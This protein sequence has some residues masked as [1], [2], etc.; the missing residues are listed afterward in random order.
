MSQEIIEMEI[1]EAG[2]PT[3]LVQGVKGKSC[4]DLTKSLEAALGT[5]VESR[6]TREMSEAPRETKQIKQR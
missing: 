4:K 3:I 2:T 5:T 6:P 1:D